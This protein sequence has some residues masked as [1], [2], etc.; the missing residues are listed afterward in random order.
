MAAAQL[1]RM[2]QGWCL[3]NL[4]AEFDRAMATWPNNVQFGQTDMLAVRR[5]VSANA[6]GCASSYCAQCNYLIQDFVSRVLRWYVT[7][8]QHNLTLQRDSGYKDSLQVYQTLS[9]I[10]IACIRHRFLCL[11]VRKDD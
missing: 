9:A 2:P 3:V 11:Q 5:V 8:G 10:T 1:P 6:C 4:Q 7:L